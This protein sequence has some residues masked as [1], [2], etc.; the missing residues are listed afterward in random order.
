MF[1]RAPGKLGTRGT[2]APPRLSQCKSFTGVSPSGK[3]R[4]LSAH[5]VAIIPRCNRN[6]TIGTADLL[7]MRGD[8]NTGPRLSLGGLDRPVWLPARVSSLSSRLGEGATLSG[9]SPFVLGPSC[10]ATPKPIPT[11]EGL[12]LRPAIRI[13]FAFRRLWPRRL[14]WLL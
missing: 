11:W 9:G 1:G 5:R 10:P 7:L 14:G 12:R 6:D 8:G 2:L 3:F 13:G 4:L